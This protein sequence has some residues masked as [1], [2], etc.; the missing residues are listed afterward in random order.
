MASKYSAA[1]YTFQF[2][3][4]T[5]GVLIALMIDG[6]VDWKSNRDLV[7]EAR[8]T[9]TRELADNK[10]D[11]ELTLSSFPRDREESLNALK[12][13]DD[14][15]HAKKT[16]RTSLNLHYNMADLSTA[17]WRTAER[18]GAL[19]HMDYAEVQKFS[20]VYDVQDV[21]L[22][23]QRMIFNQLATA[24][25]LFGGDFDPD[26]PNV[27]DLELFRERVMALQGAAMIQEDLGK[28]LVELYAEALK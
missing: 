5:A 16:S 3:T 28:H 2:V 21:F 18:T 14:L 8:A 26:Q 15:L 4:V 19:A 9:I 7:A 1:D 25:A 20:K 13:V 17:S 24:S 23:Q 10:K 12:F 22:Q 11:L 6:L 27:K